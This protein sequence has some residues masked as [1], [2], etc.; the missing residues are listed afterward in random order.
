MITE[1][2]WMK[3]SIENEYMLHIGKQLKIIQTKYITLAIK[4]MYTII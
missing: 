1:L 3:Y 4:A 2:G